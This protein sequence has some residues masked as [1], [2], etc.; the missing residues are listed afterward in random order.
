[1]SEHPGRPEIMNNHAVGS[2]WSPSVDGA[3]AAVIWAKYPTIGAGTA[4]LLVSSIRADREDLSAGTQPR[5]PFRPAAGL[6]CSLSAEIDVGRGISPGNGRSVR[7][8]SRS[9]ERHEVTNEALGESA[10]PCRDR[11]RSPVSLPRR[12]S[13]L[14]EP[15]PRPLPGA[16]CRRCA[17]HRRRTSGWR[18]RRSGLLPAH[19]ARSSRRRRCR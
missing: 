10:F 16:T 2:V 4:A 6:A 18:S 5:R 17:H 7:R 13:P 15:R 3:G 19:R 14:P 11:G 9:R 12:P 1:M 8:R